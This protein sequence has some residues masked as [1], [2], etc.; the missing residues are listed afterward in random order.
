M[1]CNCIRLRLFAEIYW[2]WW[3]KVI[4]SLDLFSLYILKCL[5]FSI[6]SYISFFIGN[7]FKLKIFFWFYTKP[8]HIFAEKC[9]FLFL[10]IQ[11]IMLEVFSFS[12]KV[13]YTTYCTVHYTFTVCKGGGTWGGGLIFF[14]F[15]Q[16]KPSFPLLFAWSQLDISPT[17]DS[18]SAVSEGLST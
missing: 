17:S 4:W 14:L 15:L 9:P 8:D 12:K 1:C 10:S 3:Q 13:K 11:L 16:T 2:W 6:S 18:V 5:T 7:Y